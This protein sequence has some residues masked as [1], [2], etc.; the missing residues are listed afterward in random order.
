MES[1]QR[2]RFQ[3]IIAI[4]L[5]LVV[6]RTAYLFYQ[7]HKSNEQPGPKQPEYS[8]NLDD[9]VSIPKVYFYDLKSAQKELSEKTVWVKAGNQIPYYRYNQ[10][11]KQA[12][13]KREAG[14]LAPLEKLE[15]KNVTSQRVPRTLSE[16][17]IAV[18][19]YDILAVF[20]PAKEA[21]TY[22]VSIGK[23]VGDDFT[24]T[25][26]E[27]F[28]FADPHKLY[29]HWPPEIWKAIDEHKAVP[30][31]NELQVSLALGTA[32]SISPG[33]YG[34]RSIEYSNNGIPVKVTFEH[35]KAVSVTPA[36][37]Q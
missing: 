22:A 15:I 12:E 23:S 18:V 21:G 26:N 20:T 35:N 34:N 10:Q 3:I 30:G 17:Q 11:S 36:D 33:D 2:K 37:A 4:L 27:L 29:S 16:G 13:L 14:L 7:R 19:Q 25:A 28:F 8:S 24:A 32:G 31:M 6:A 9:Y 1:D 5:V